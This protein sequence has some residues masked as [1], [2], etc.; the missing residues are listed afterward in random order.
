MANKLSPAEQLALDDLQKT[1]LR[2]RPPAL[3]PDQGAEA[4]A[5]HKLLATTVHRA[6]LLDA[7]GSE[8]QTRAWVRYFTEHFPRGRNGSSDAELL[9]KE[10]RTHLLKQ[11]SPGPMVPITHG[12]P[13]LHWQRDSAGRLCI[14]L[15]TMWDD[16]AQS[17]EHLVGYLQVTPERR[18]VALTRLKESTW[19][20]QFFTVSNES[21]PVT[22]ATAMA[23]ATVGPP[24]T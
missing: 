21:V 12:K 15:E 24:K 6:T 7:L 3:G 19:A 11:D 1:L 9:W 8:S 13:H 23:S 4:F 5:Q 16:Y 17:V 14:D 22:G 20:V 18:E 10:W 2:G